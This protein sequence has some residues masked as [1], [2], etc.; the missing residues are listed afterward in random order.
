[1]IRWGVLG[2]GNI[3][4]RF[5]SS[6]KYSKTGELYAVASYTK[7]KR[8]DFKLNNP[9]IVVYDDYESILMDPNIDVVY[10]A[11]RHK[12]HYRLSK[13][14]L[15]HHKAVLCEKPACFSEEQAK[16]L[17]Q[18]SKENNVFYMEGLKSRFIPAINELKQM[19]NSGKLGTV[20]HMETSFCNVAEYDEN[21]YL[22]DNEQGGAFYDLAS[23]NIASITDY[24]NFD[25]YEVI[26]KSEFNYGVDTYD[27]IELKFDNGSDAVIEVGIDRESSRELLIKTTN[28]KISAKPFY[29]PSTINIVMDDGEVII[30]DKP[31]EVDDFFGEIEEVHT[32]IKDKKIESSRL[33]HSNII[34]NTKIFEELKSIVSK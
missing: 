1:M 29:R 12:D 3:S 17:C 27:L 5:R 20:T 32:C 14:A 19:F 8:D 16:E 25:S 10:I 2:L 34:Y 15:I 24:M 26:C 4:E 28:A 21:S 7:K 31:Y 23:Y 9:G 22:F 33:T 18:I 6:L 11:A 13:E 30:I